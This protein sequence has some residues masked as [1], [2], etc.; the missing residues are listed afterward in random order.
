M[1]CVSERPCWYDGRLS[2]DQRILQTY[3]Y[4]RSSSL[5]NACQ[6]FDALIISKQRTERQKREKLPFF[7][8]QPSV[9]AEQSSFQKFILNS[10]WTVQ[11]YIVRHIH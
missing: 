3:L 10:H 1:F 2:I 8:S 7:T 6:L 5:F 9:Y 11:R 4:A